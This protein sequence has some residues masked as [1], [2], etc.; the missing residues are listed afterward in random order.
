MDDGIDRRR[1]LAA[2]AAAT[3]LTLGAL[4]LPG[5]VSP[6]FWSLEEEVLVRQNRSDFDVVVNDPPRSSVLRR[7]ARAAPVGMDLGLIP[8]RMIN[9]MNASDGVGLAGPQVGLSLR[10]AAVLLD[11]DSDSPRTLF[12][13]NPVITSR[14]NDSALGWEGCLSIPDVGGRVRRNRRITVEYSLATGE[15]ISEEAEGFNAAIWQHEIDHL[16]GVL[17]TDRL[18]GKLLPWEK[19][20]LR[21]KEGG[22][23]TR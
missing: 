11:H 2:S 3:G 19:V 17:Y 20:L 13:L 18:V 9:T 5:C 7:R 1:F 4:A 10:V 6:P 21:R 16:D 8:E 15:R 12:A 14:S 23:N 22:H